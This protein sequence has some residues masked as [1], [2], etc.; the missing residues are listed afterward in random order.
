MFTDNGTA[1]ISLP[2]GSY[3][4][5]TAITSG[6]G[7][8]PSPWASISASWQDHGPLDKV[9]GGGMRVAELHAVDGMGNVT[10]RKYLY[11]LASAPTRSSGDVTTE[12]VYSLQFEGENCQYF[13]R[14][15]FSRMPLG[16][17]GGLV[18]YREV[19]VWQ[20]ANG[21]F[22]KTL[23]RFRSAADAPDGSLPVG[24][25]PFERRPS[26]EWKRGQEWQAIQQNAAQQP[27]RETRSVYAF[28]D[29]T[30]D[31]TTRS[32][33]GLSVSFFADGSLQGYT[34]RLSPF[35][36]LSAWTRLESDTTR[37]YDES[38]GGPVVSARSLIYGN[39]NH[40]QL[41]E[42]QETNSDGTQ[43]I[44]R[45][46]YPA[47]YD[48]LNVVAGT[49][50]AALKAMRGDPGSP[51]HMPGVVIERW[52]SVR[53]GTSDRVVQA[54]ITTFKEFAT[55]QFLPYKHYVLNSPSPPP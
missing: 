21:E 8:P 19:M 30:Q 51:I 44:T 26:F 53:N 23:H 31:P 33:R 2:P 54:E 27:Q 11:T 1:Q 40:L 4:L 15:S 9:T 7:Q 49:E 35:V 52:V 50:A 28:L 29:E 39:P 24:V 45:L 42:T 25:W 43:R 55:G 47:D 12:P 13:V 14:G 36:V 41:T 38:G 5:Q 16:D 17:G 3:T 18:G 22:G 34:W 48:T 46:K 6:G 20:G 37:I 32:Q 10:V